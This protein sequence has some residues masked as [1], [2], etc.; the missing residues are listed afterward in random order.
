MPSDGLG[1]DMQREI[2]MIYE[3]QAP[4]KAMVHLR[5]TTAGLRKGILRPVL[6]L[7]SNDNFDCGKL[8]KVKG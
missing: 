8:C 3:T 1:L 4:Q 2:S 7:V 6:K 5:V